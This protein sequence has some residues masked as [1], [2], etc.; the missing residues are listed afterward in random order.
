MVYM[1]LRF[2][3]FLTRFLACRGKLFFFFCQALAVI[4]RLTY[5]YHNLDKCRLD[6]KLPWLC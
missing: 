4:T 5:V 2:Q 6:L 1:E 3:L